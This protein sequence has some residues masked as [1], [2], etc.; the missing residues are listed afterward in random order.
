MLQDDPNARPT[1]EEVLQH[2]FLLKTE[3]DHSLVKIS[4]SLLEL[5][6]K[7]F[8]YIVGLENLNKS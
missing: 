4:D 7:Y 3:K 2:K 1:A 6:K 8:L 5:I